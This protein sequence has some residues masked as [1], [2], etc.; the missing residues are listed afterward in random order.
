MIQCLESV[1]QY[2]CRLIAEGW[3]FGNAGAYGYLPVTV[4]GIAPG[5]DNLTI[6]LERGV[7]LNG[8]VTEKETGMPAVG[9]V[10]NIA[11]REMR[12]NDERI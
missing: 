9:A 10:V 4:G 1:G 7:I 3:I 6:V 8:S 5:F 11:Y 2:L 12:I